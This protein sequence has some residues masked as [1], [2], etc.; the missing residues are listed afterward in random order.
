[1]DI[2]T[3]KDKIIN[4]LLVENEFNFSNKVIDFNC[5]KL[6]KELKVDRSNTSRIK[7][8]MIFNNEIELIT[9]N[10]VKFLNPEKYYYNYSNLVKDIE[11]IKEYKLSDNYIRLL[12]YLHYNYTK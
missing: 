10:K 8:E 1:M 11:S 7:Q 4:H 12:G 2:M 3:V 9:P 6:S 5:N